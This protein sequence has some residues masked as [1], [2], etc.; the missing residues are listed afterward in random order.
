M[1]S[2]REQFM[3]EVEENNTTTLTRTMASRDSQYLK[4]LEAK[5]TQSEEDKKNILKAFDIYRN[6]TF[7]NDGAL[8]LLLVFESEKNLAI[9]SLQ[10]KRWFEDKKKTHFN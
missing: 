9:N 4:W 2:L 10:V 3:Y 8:E 1:D 6:I 7:S 5:L